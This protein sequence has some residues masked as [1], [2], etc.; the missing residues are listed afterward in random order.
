MRAN[1]TKRVSALDSR[2][3]GE[4]G[5]SMERVNEE[6]SFSTLHISNIRIIRI[7]LSALDS[8]QTS[9]LLFGLTHLALKTY[10]YMYVIEK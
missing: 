7:F 3:I 9:V 2:P 5:P 1:Y 10:V 8:T 4:K 6:Y